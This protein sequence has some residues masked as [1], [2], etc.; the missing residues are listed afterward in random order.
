[1]QKRNLKTPVVDEHARRPRSR[2]TLFVLMLSVTAAARCSIAVADAPRR[3]NG[4]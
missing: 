3:G 4:H 1:M 2:T